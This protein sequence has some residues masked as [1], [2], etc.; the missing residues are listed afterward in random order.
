MRLWA[1][2]EEGEEQQERR[3][4]QMKTERHAND[5]TYLY[6]NIAQALLGTR[7]EG[8]QELVRGSVASF[9][10]ELETSFAGLGI[11]SLAGTVWAV[12]YFVLLLLVGMLLCYMFFY[13]FIQSRGLIRDVAKFASCTQFIRFARGI[14]MKARILIPK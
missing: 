4:V 1:E 10:G 13:P 8:R 7:K 12:A 6:G 5:P 11:R 3:A 9:S 2:A 14:Q